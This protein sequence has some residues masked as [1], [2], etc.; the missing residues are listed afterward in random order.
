LQQKQ[1]Q[2]QSQQN[3]YSKVQIKK[4]P[5]IITQLI[6]NERS[7][8]NESYNQQSHNN[9][10]YNL[11][12]SN[13]QTTNVN[14]IVRKSESYVMIIDQGTKLIFPDMDYPVEVTTFAPN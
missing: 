10:A 12:T 9:R 11:S 8:N 13:D 1:L 5:R 14:P 3:N 2:Q 7:S 4:K 6:S